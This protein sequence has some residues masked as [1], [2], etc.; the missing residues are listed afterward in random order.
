M[1]VEGNDLSDMSPYEYF[2][3]MFPLHHLSLIVALTNINLAKKGKIVT[4]G[5]EILKMFRVF[6]LMTRFEFTDRR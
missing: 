4:T 2:L 6:V 5:G 1:I 3:W